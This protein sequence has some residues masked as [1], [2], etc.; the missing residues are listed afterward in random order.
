MNVC[1]VV[2]V[3]DHFYY[4]SFSFPFLWKKKAS[5]RRKTENSVMKAELSCGWGKK[6][7]NKKRERNW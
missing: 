4:E 1:I 2:S 6:E 3:F 5:F 7:K